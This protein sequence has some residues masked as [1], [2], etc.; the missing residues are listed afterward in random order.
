MLLKSILSQ[1]S[2]KTLDITE[3]DPNQTDFLDQKLTITDLNDFNENLSFH[4]EYNLDKETKN[5]NSDPTHLIEVPMDD[6]IKID[7]KE[8]EDLKEV[9][10][11]KEVEENM[12]LCDYIKNA[13][14]KMFG[15]NNPNNQ[16]ILETIQNDQDFIN[17]LDA[18]NLENSTIIND[19]LIKL[20]NKLIFFNLDEKY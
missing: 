10:D 5:I 20:K 15:T 3:F 1:E 12:S 16:D 18:S 14:S 7:I 11:I 6:E 17:D 8:V 19:K 4:I 9:E 13:I 2:K